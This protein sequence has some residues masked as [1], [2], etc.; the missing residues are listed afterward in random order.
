MSETPNAQPNVPE[1]TPPTI[2]GVCLIEIWRLRDNKAPSA[3]WRE[4][5]AD[6]VFSLWR[7]MEP[8]FAKKALKAQS[9]TLDKDNHECQY[10]ARAFD[11]AK[12]ATTED[13]KRIRKLRDAFRNASDPAFICQACQ[14]SKEIQATRPLPGGK[15]QRFVVECP[16]CA[17]QPPKPEGDEG[18]TSTAEDAREQAERNAAAEQHVENFGGSPHG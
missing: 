7:F 13:Y 6:G 3:F 10:A 16:E 15:V 4:V 1:G 5:Q 12:N 17:P 2:K 11:S 18:T 9:F 8:S 14:G